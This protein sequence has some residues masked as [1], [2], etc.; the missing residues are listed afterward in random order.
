MT[1]EEIEEWLVDSLYEDIL[2]ADNL[3]GGF[4]G[5]AA[6]HGSDPVA[7]YDRDLC[8]ESLV[9]NDG[10]EY[11]EAIEFYEFNICSAYMGKKTPMFLS[12]PPQLT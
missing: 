10:M 11:L 2:L 3:D 8:L 5:I 12:R 4:I 6:Q 9:E 1:R 7:V